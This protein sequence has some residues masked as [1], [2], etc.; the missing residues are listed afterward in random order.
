MF[1]I[2]TAVVLVVLAALAWWSSG[3][4][5][6]RQDI[7]RGVDVANTETRAQRGLSNENGMGRPQ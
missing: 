2:V 3:R 5:K 4:A 6:P 7:Q 1:W